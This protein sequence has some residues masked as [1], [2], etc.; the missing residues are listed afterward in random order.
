M[1]IKGTVERAF[2]LAS[3]GEFRNIAEVQ[4]QLEREG[5]SSTADHLSGSSI[6]RQL[7][8]LVKASRAAAPAQP[9]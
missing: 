8:V 5:Y 1:M 2:E 6:R 7:R 9:A 4:K 3:S